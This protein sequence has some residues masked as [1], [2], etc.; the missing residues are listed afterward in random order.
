MNANWCTLP[1]NRMYEKLPTRQQ[2]G[3]KEPLTVGQLP[4]LCIQTM[5]VRTF[6][7]MECCVRLGRSRV[8][9]NASGKTT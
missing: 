8:Q 2:L 1:R 4:S 3:K 6:C 7:S 5:Q 9:Q